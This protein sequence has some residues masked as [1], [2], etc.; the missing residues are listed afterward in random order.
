MKIP[1]P[2]RG[3]GQPLYIDK[4]EIEG[5]QKQAAQVARGGLCKLCKMDKACGHGLCETC[6]L[7]A[8]RTGRPRPQYLIEAALHRR[9]MKKE[10]NS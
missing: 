7:Y 8:R 4:I 10:A 2:N 9:Q 6:A 1:N 3:K 5:V